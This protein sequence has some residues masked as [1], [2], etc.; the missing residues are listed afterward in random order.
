MPRLGPA[1]QETEDSM[2]T[3]VRHEP[4]WSVSE[5][6]AQTQ[7][8]LEYDT[9][10]HARDAVTG[11][12]FLPV[13]LVGTDPRCKPVRQAIVTVFG[14]SLTVDNRERIAAEIVDRCNRSKLAL[15]DIADANLLD[16]LNVLSGTETTGDGPPAD[17]SSN[18]K[19]GDAN[20]RRI[21]WT[22][23]QVNGA[24]QRYLDE[25]KEAQEAARAKRPGA[26]KIAKKIFGRNLIARELDIPA[27]AMVGKSPAWRALADELGITSNRSSGKS[28]IGLDIALEQ[29]AEEA[30]DTTAN[31][32]E[33]RDIIKAIETAKLAGDAPEHEQEKAR[34]IMI[35]EIEA[36]RI[37]LDL[38][39][40]ILEASQLPV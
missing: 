27:Q 35:N 16:L 36:G 12:L 1:Q 29:Q 24:V 32:V 7:N 15:R 14:E 8:S 2:N 23:P 30:G 10:E 21:E 17:I 38:A 34:L 22:Q 19:P 37:S 31:K 11:K 33:K 13:L 39:N 26:L 20:C 18:S 5:A 6:T 9:L 25:R 28:K 3:E 4:E 40:E